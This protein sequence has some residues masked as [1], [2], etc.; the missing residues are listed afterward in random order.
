MLGFALLT[1][2]VT[3]RSIDFTVSGTLDV[4]SAGTVSGRSMRVI[5]AVFVMVH[6]AV[7]ESTL[8]V[9]VSFALKPFESV[10][11][12]QIPVRFVYVPWLAP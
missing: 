10:P 4:L 7:S 5:V 11:T 2:F 8:A 6:D 3:P 12:S 1:L 9:M